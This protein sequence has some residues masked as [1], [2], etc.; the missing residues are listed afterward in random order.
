MIEFLIL[1]VQAGQREHDKWQSHGSG[2]ESRPG[3]D[4]RAGLWETGEHGRRLRQRG[5]GNPMASVTDFLN[6]FDEEGR[7][8]ALDGVLDV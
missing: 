1:L 8:S 4:G 2:D 5:E 3:I 7:Y 6:Q